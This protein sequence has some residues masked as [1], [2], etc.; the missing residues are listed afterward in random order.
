MGTGA[1]NTAALAFGGE[2]P[3]NT[4]K[5]ENWNGAVWV[6][7]AD[8]NVSQADGNGAGTTAAAVAF[9]GASAPKAMTEEWNGSSNTTKVLTD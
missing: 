4:G 5:T 3:P 8:L 2:A 9:G 6:E 1:S 7:V